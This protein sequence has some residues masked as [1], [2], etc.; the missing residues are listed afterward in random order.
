MEMNDPRSNQEGF[1]FG[2][3]IEA[4]RCI[5]Q[6]KKLHFLRLVQIQALFVSGGTLPTMHMCVHGWTH[7]SCVYICVRG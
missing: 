2:S 6:A 7:S 5:V 4:G 1:H 3:I